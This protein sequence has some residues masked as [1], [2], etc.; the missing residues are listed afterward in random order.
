MRAFGKMMNV[1]LKIVL[2]PLIVAATL[3]EWIGTLII[4][5]SGWIF[6]LISGV[7][8]LAALLGCG[9]GI[10]S[11]EEVRSM[12]IGGCI[13]FVLPHIAGLIVGVEG[14]VGVVMREALS[15]R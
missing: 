5:I 12:L 8:I 11:G 7:V 3:T 15:G 6:Y 9:F 13:F 1:V 14:A 4:G 10:F 2:L